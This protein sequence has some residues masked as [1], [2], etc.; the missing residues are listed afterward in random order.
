MIAR[1]LLLCGA[2]VLIAS[3]VADNGNNTPAAATESA[4]PPGLAIAGGDTA[5]SAPI[6]Q[7]TAATATASEAATASA[8][9][10]DARQ[11][12]AS[13]A[14]SAVVGNSVPSGAVTNTI[15]NGKIGSEMLV[16]RIPSGT[17]ITVALAA[18][19]CTLT[20]KAGEEFDAIVSTDVAGSLDASIPAGSTVQF[21]LVEF[22]KAENITDQARVTVQP[23]RVTTG[24]GSFDVSASTEAPPYETRR[25]Q[26]KKNSIK[27][28]LLG[29]LGG[30]LA[31]RLRGGSAQEI[32]MAAA[33][34]A[35]AGG[36]IGAGVTDTHICLR[37]G[38]PFH[39]TLDRAIEMQ[40]R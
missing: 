28:A 37:A 36:A 14:A 15:S 29:G 31:G 8:I 32:E 16:G 18:E 7:D 17:S 1:L 3:C 33:A 21:K 38:A 26:I 22:A 20:K 10:V 35:A 12:E 9:I 13:S 5:L 27:G 34:G 11:P 25:P 6:T 39:I 4:S 2:A 24:S 19:V 23:L 30:A 40:K